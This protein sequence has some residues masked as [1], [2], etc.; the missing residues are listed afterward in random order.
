MKQTSTKQAKKNRELQRIK[1]ELQ[2]EHGELCMICKSER[3]SDL[4]HILPKGIYPEHYTEKWNL[5]L[6]CRSCHELFDSSAAYRR[7]T[8]FYA[9]VSKHDY[10]GAYRYF[11]MHNV[12]KI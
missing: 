6:G 5:A 12:V 2:Q 1:K 8:S 10:H 11:Q 4:M 9:Q 7:K 3:S